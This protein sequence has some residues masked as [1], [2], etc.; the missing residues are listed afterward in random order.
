MWCGLHNV[1]ALC[2]FADQLILVSISAKIQNSY[3]QHATW[4]ETNVVKYI[5]D[6]CNPVLDEA[7]EDMI[8]SDGDAGQENNN[9]AL[10][11]DN[12]ENEDEYL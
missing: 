5:I 4:L 9:N 1:R 6:F 7:F 10:N 3:V 12:D 8:F 2:G 11:D